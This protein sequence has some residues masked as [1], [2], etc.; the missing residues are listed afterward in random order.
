MNVVRSD[1][2]NP[3]FLRLCRRLDA[4]IDALVGRE[5]RQKYAPFNTTEKLHDVVLIYE[6]SAAIACGALRHYEEGVAEIKRVFVSDEFRGRGYGR[7]IISELEMLARAGG[8]RSVILETGDAIEAACALYG[9]TGFTRC[10]NYGPY[11]D[12]P[13]SVCMKKELLS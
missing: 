12:M 4:A 7:C 13:E 8:Y 6:G 5:E 2:N 10:E 3:D 9:K 11:R 1:G